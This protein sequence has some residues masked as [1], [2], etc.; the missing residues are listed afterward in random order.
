MNEL[1]QSSRVT[2]ALRVIERMNEGANVKD[3]CLEVG[4]PRSTF[5][6]ILARDP[7][8]I[9]TFQDMITAN[10]RERLYLALDSQT[11]ILEKVI[12]DGL[13]DDT[14]PRDRLAIYEK[15]GE[16]SAALSDQLQESGPE[17]KI[18]AMVLP[19]IVFRRGENRIANRPDFSTDGFVGSDTGNGS[20]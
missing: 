20:E 6:S 3:A 18:A 11:R 2:T 10:T 17:E 15:L 14:K 12:A 13:S 5:Y 9:T 7:L 19:T 16:I 4:M 1:A 8:A